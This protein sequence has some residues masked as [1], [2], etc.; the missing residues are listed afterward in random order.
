MQNE[1]KSTIDHNLHKYGVTIERRMG[2]MR[3]D[4]LAE[5]RECI[6]KGIVTFKKTGDANF[7]TYINSCVNNR[8]KTLAR[9]SQTKKAT[10][11]DY[12]DDVYDSVGVME[13]YTL[14]TGEIAFERKQKFEK[15]LNALSG[16]ERTVLSKMIVGST[17]SEIEDKTK[18]PRSKVIAAVKNV[19]VVVNQFA[20]EQ[21]I[22]ET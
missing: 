11:L 14:D 4:L 2:L 7:K 15:Y 8:F 5:V 21:E 6:W 20:S 16:F 1:L 19:Y 10:S 13:S 9:L 17:L 22:E 12:Y 3:D 18:A